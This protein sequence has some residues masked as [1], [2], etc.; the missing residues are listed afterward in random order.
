MKKENPENI[1]Q[2]VTWDDKQEVTEENM[3]EV[4]NFAKTDLQRDIEECETQSLYITKD[5][6][7][8][9]YQLKLFKDDKEIVKAL[10]EKLAECHSRIKDWTL[11]AQSK[12]R[13]Q[14]AL[15]I[16]CRQ[17]GYQKLIREGKLKP[18]IDNYDEET[19]W[20]TKDLPPLS[21]KEIHEA[22]MLYKKMLKG[23][24]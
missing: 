15:I 19:T 11:E 23:K 6:E 10:N 20:I 21:Y 8:I 7:M 4:N 12:K 16:Y 22:H 2:E 9:Q 17:L 3:V 24:K 13:Y 1:Q 5:I 14:S 18:D